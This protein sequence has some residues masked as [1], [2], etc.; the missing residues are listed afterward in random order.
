[1]NVAEA[2]NHETSEWQNL[3]IVTQIFFKLV[4]SI[5]I[6]SNVVDDCENDEY[7]RLQVFEEN[8][9]QLE[10]CLTEAFILIH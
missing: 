3:L 4:H 5:A 10:K 9:N 8:E 2:L 6:E 1:M 7:Q